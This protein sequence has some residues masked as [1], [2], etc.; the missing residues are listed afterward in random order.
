M[1]RLLSMLFVIAF[2]GGNDA[3]CRGAR[4]NNRVN[5]GEFWKAIRWNGKY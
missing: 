5:S 4:R 2:G 1:R 3:N